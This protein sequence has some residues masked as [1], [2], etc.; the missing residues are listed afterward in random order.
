[1][2]L[3]LHRKF[4]GEVLP[5]LE[6]NKKQNE[7]EVKENIEMPELIGNS[8]DESKKILKKLNLEFEISGEESAESKVIDQLPKKGIQVQ[9]GTKVILYIN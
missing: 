4:Y 7:I 6:V 9:E 2:Q 1:M 3:L 5:Y 8:L